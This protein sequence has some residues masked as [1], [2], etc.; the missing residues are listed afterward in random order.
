MILHKYLILLFFS[1]QCVGQN[2][3]MLKNGKYELK[4]D[5]I[6][7]N[8]TFFQ[9]NEN[10][11]STIINEENKYFEIKIIDKCSFQLKNNEIIDDSKLTEFQKILSKQTFYYE[12]T[13]VEGDI[14]YFICWVNLHIQCGKGMFIKIE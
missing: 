9:I 4:Y 11:Y 14:Y 12:I 5:S 6:N 10:K 13:K 2:C 3:S 7:Q 8:S 1:F